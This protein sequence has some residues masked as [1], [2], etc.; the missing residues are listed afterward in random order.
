MV[1]RP[2][3]NPHLQKPEIDKQTSEMLQAGIIH[4]STCCYSFLVIMVTKDSSWRLWIDYHALNALTVKDKFPIPLIDDLLDDLSH[5]I[6]FSNLDLPSRYHHIHMAENDIHKTAFQTNKGHYGIVAMPFELT[7]APSTFQ[8]LMNNIFHEF[9]RQF[10][11][12]FFDDKLI[13]SSSWF[14]HLRHFQQ[15]LEILCVHVL[16]VRKEKYSFCKTWVFH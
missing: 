2:W 15:T 12:V 4:H 9:S 3:R 6:V 11:L 14:D 7:N 10:T 1:F 13:Y 8:S 16:F 5:A